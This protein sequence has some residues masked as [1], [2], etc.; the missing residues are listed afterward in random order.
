MSD[1]ENGFKTACSVCGTAYWS[2]D[3]KMCNCREAGQES[4]SPGEEMEAKVMKKVNGA[5]SIN[6]V[7]IDAVE[8]PKPFNTV[9]VLDSAADADKRLW[10]LSTLLPNDGIGHYKTDVIIE[11]GDGVKIKTRHDLKHC[12][13]DGTVLE[14]AEWFLRNV[15]KNAHSIFSEKER[16]EAQG[17]LDRIK[18]IRLAAPEPEASEDVSVG[19]TL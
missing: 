4:I 16:I 8:M 5:C 15:V 17:L 19:P 2:D 7:T 18:K 9:S 3:G 6:K 10:F 14:H 1:F 12:D 13:T 11:F